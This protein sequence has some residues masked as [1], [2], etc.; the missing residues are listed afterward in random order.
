MQLIRSN[1][2]KWKKIFCAK[3]RIKIEKQNQTK[4]EKIIEKRKFI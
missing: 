3:I 4:N 1:E 2:K